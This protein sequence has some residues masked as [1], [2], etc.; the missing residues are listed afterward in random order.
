MIHSNV[1]VCA[2]VCET[3]SVDCHCCVCVF[4]DRTVEAVAGC[5]GAWADKQGPHSPQHPAVIIQDWKD[6]KSFGDILTEM[7]MWLHSGLWNPC[8]LVYRCE[9]EVSALYYNSRTLRKIW[10]KMLLMKSSWILK[11]NNSRCGNPEKHVILSAIV[12]SLIIHAIT[13]KYTAHITLNIVSS[14]FVLLILW[15]ETLCRSSQ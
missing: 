4:C 1:C 15:K 14:K 5:D 7:W 10:W 13:Y 2:R 6:D 8:Q 11:K 9:C 3:S 12:H